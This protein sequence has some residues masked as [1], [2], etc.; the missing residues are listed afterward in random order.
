MKPS[1]LYMDFTIESDILFSPI[2]IAYP[3]N[4]C[5]FSNRF[6]NEWI[7]YANK[8]QQLSAMTFVQRSVQEKTRNTEINRVCLSVFFIMTIKLCIRQFL[9]KY[10]NDTRQT[11]K[12]LRTMI[13]F[14]P[15]W[16][17]LCRSLCL[18][19]HWI[20]MNRSHSVR[21]D[22]LTIKQHRSSQLLFLR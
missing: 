5:V 8:K 15:Y 6:R 9:L 16:R 21:Y 4:C 10:A 1:V 17:L 7:K 2:K 12:K 20:E 22:S 19:K 14:S 11:Q 18:W 3:V 13:L